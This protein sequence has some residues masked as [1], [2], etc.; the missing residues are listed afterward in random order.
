MYG[1]PAQKFL[2]SAPPLT[3]SPEPHG[4][5]VPTA[6]VAPSPQPMGE[7]DLPTKSVSVI[8]LYPLPPALHPAIQAGRPPPGTSSRQDIFS[9]SPNLPATTASPSSTLEIDKARCQGTLIHTLALPIF[10]LP[11]AKPR[12]RPPLHCV[13]ESYAVSREPA[14]EATLE[15]RISPSVCSHKGIRIPVRTPPARQASYAGNSAVG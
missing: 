2:F 10:P 4:C 7:D 5:A 11:S 13:N 9:L 3:Q 8:T 6:L 1:A 12:R 15:V 14:G